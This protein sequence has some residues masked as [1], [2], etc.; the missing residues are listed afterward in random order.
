MFF[1]A[2]L[3][4]RLKDGYPVPMFNGYLAKYECMEIVWLVSPGINRD[5]L[6]GAVASDADVV[7]PCLEDG[8]PYTEEAKSEARKNV[9]ELLDERD[10]QGPTVRPRINE[11]TSEYWRADVEAVV[12]ANPDGLIVPDAKSTENLQDLSL[13]VRELE[14]EHGLEENSIDIS[15]LVENPRGVRKTYDLSSADNRVVATM[16]GADDYTQ[17]LRGLKEDEKRIATVRSVLDYPRAKIAMEARAAGVGAVDSAAIA[18]DD[19]YILEESN[20]AARMGFSGKM[21]LH[22]SQIPAIRRGFAPT[23]AEVDR[24]RETIEI[25]EEDGGGIVNGMVV[26]APVAKQARFILERYDELGAREDI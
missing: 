26:V 23:R 24:A 15:V 5:K 4:T 14:R 13:Y 10:G 3:R 16:F 9:V 12:P 20:K 19:E 21:A 8:T 1:L 2:T 6:A 18:I 17:H 25:Y 11:L 7:F 22:P